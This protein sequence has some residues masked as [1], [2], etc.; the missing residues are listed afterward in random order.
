MKGSKWRS[1]ETVVM[2][3]PSPDAANRVIEQGVYWG[4]SVL[5]VEPF[6][7]GV[8][9]LRCF[10]CQNY[11][12]VAFKCRSTARCGWCADHGHKTEECGIRGQT[13]SKACAPCI[14][15]RGHCALDHGCP[16]RLREESIAKAVYNGRPRRFETG[17]LV[18]QKSPGA[19]PPRPATPEDEGFVVVTGGKR[20]RAPGR[21]TAVSQACTSGMPT[22][23]ACFQKALA[24]Q[25]TGQGN[26]SSREVASDDDVEMMVE[27]QLHE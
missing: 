5:R 14:G 6:A 22:I 25:A 4:R 13:A 1:S 18:R 7:K 8:K 20:K 9:P 3:S 15:A 26:D 2:G 11:G 21:P 17:R 27:Q 19:G 10:K 24:S 23:A 16:T 12:H